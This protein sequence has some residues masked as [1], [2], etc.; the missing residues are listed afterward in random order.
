[1]C[2]RVSTGTI[3]HT[4]T[5]PMASGKY[6]FATE[7]SRCLATIHCLVKKGFRLMHFFARTG[8]IGRQSS[9]RGHEPEI[10]EKA[11]LYVG[12]I[13]AGEDTDQAWLGCTLPTGCVDEIVGKIEAETTTEE[14]DSN[15]SS[16]SSPP[17]AKKQKKQSKK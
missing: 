13:G 7:V 3:V 12:C 4:Y 5:A 11:K 10:K 15:N 1:M 17:P 14:S 16:R 2:I 9:L 8:S 6:K